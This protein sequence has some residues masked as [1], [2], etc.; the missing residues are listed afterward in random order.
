MAIRKNSIRELNDN[1]SIRTKRISSHSLTNSNKTKRI[2]LHFRYIRKIKYLMSN[3]VFNHIEDFLFQENKDIL[4]NQYK[5]FKNQEMSAWETQ[6]TYQ[7]LFDKYHNSINTL[8]KQHKFKV[9]NKI[10]IERYKKDTKYAKKGDI[11]SIKIVF[12]TTPLTRLM[13]WLIYIE[14]D[15]L[16]TVLKSYKENATIEVNNKVKAFNDYLN[17]IRNNEKLWERIKALILMKQQRIISKVK[18]I[19][20]K[21]GSYRKAYKENPNVATVGSEVFIDHSNKYLKHFYKF[22]IAKKEILYLPLAYNKDFH[23]H[24]KNINLNANHYVSLNDKGQINI[25]LQ[26]TFKQT[27][28]ETI[29]IEQIAGID[30]N[31]KHNFCVINID[32]D[33]IEYDYDRDFFQKQINELKAIDAIGYNQLSIE[34]K[35]KLQKIVKRTESYFQSLVSEILDSLQNKAITEIVLEDLNLQKTGFKTFSEEFGVSYNRLV[36]ILRLNQVKH[37]FK[38]QANK[39][40]IKVHFTSP[41]ATS[42]ECSV[43][44]HIDKDNRRKQ[45]EFKCVNCGHTI[46]ADNQASHNISNRIKL[47]VLRDRL[48]NYDMYGQ[49]TPKIMTR[50]NI[51]NTIE[52]YYLKQSTLNVDPHNSRLLRETN[53]KSLI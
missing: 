21:T 10:K 49:C 2:Q 52:N 23:N 51:K 9:Q 4:G 15:K 43:C 40:G 31:I 42:I 27:F 18:K 16:D 12:K 30:L 46:N 39:R 36:K 24:F 22:K 6:Q 44:H 50:D 37:W 11:K 53:S 26:E 47:D 29:S 19:V 3:Y 5:Q 17:K 13:N 14:K 28:K 33:Y 32:E 7:E 8:K 35:R 34:N 20:P 38:N 25:G 1:K 45:K 41:C 48:H